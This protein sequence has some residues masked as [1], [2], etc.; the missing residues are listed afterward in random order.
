MKEKM[1][2]GKAI[3]TCFSKLFTFEGR[4]RRSEFWYFYL[5]ISII[6]LTYMTFG[7]M[8]DSI[9]APTLGENTD[10]MIK[11][12]GPLIN[13]TVSI[14]F[15]LI[16]LSVS[17]RRLHDI[18]CSGWLIIPLIVLPD[19]IAMLYNRY[20]PSTDALLKS[21]EVTPEAFAG[22]AVTIIFVLFFFLGITAVKIILFCKAGTE[23]PNQYGPDPIRIIEK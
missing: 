10:N 8:F 7:F 18:E 13:N 3:S 6:G 19:I 14:I 22:I 9:I 23:G 5:L 20:W 12:S 11:L 15:F 16:E 4:A 17:V 21:G 2:F 1:S